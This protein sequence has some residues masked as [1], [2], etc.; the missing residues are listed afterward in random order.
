NELKC[1]FSDSCDVNLET[2][3]HC[4]YCRLKKCFSVGMKKQWIR[5]EDEKLKKR[6]QIENNRRIKQQK[7]TQLISS[8]NLLHDDTSKLSMDE[9]TLLN[10]ITYSY[11]QRACMST[12]AT[13][14]LSSSLI[15]V[16]KFPVHGYVNWKLNVMT[17][18]LAYFK[19]IPE[20]QQLSLDD[21]VLL[22]KLNLR[23][24]L[25][26]NYCLIHSVIKQ[27]SYIQ[28]II[29]ISDIDSNIIRSSTAIAQT[30]NSFIQDPLIMKLMLIILL[31]TTNLL[32]LDTTISFELI[33]LNYIQHVQLYYT[34]L[35]WTYL[36]Y[37]FGEYDAQVLLMKLT[38][39]CLKM[40]YNVCEIYDFIRKNV[41]SDRVQPLVKCITHL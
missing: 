21:Q 35:L 4:T 16:I 23:I 29:L 34:Q 28:T 26:M 17:D 40:Q 13:L 15:T 10:N 32:T 38:F 9:W 39:K 7:A 8:I 14:T 6:R 12:I 22:T 36:T 25:P 31:F 30:F 5:T 1:R 3:R 33:Q 18:L 20:F 41:D 24:I 37:K 19:L 27:S 2:R 11:D